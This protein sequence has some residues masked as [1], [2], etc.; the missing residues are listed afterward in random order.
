MII[1]YKKF[2]VKSQLDYF[3]VI[4][5]LHTQNENFGGRNA[6]LGS[7]YTDSIILSI[8]QQSLNMKKS[9][10]QEHSMSRNRAS[11]STYFLA[12]LILLFNM[13][14]KYYVRIYSLTSQESIKNT[15]TEGNRQL[16]PS[17]PPKRTNHHH[18][19][20]EVVPRCRNA[21]SAHW[22]IL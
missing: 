14:I 15:S 2:V 17:P 18:R 10:F 16:R 4:L 19:L 5:D 11:I 21:Y 7:L 22:L 13:K 6:Q 1:L 20:A 12:I 8:N 9:T 3:S